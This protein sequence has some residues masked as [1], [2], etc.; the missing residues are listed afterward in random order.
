M[1]ALIHVNGHALRRD[2]DLRQGG[3]GLRGPR[4]ARLAVARKG[5]QPENPPNFGWLRSLSPRKFRMM[6]IQQPAINKILGRRW[7]N[8]MEVPMVTDIMFLQCGNNIGASALSSTRA[9]SPTTLNVARIPRSESI[10][11]SRFAASS[12]AGSK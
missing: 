3:D 6:L 7:M 11:A 10:S 4:G 2:A 8:G 5:F 1:R 12:S 9:F